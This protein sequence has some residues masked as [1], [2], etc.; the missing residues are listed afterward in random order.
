MH[1][2]CE[3]AVFKLTHRF[4]LILQRPSFGISHDRR[5]P[6]PQGPLYATE[7]E[8]LQRRDCT[9]QAKRGSGSSKEA[10]LKI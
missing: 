10:G 6:D 2:K 4:I 9:T 5:S 7:S 3:D 8:F 1:T